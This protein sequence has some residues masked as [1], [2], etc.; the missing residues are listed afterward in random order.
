MEEKKGIYQIL[1]QVV[2][3]FAKAIPNLVGAILVLVIGWIIAKVVAKA[4]ATVLEKLGVDKAANK[5][6]QIDFMQKA[7]LNLMPSKVIPGLVYYIILL[8]FAMVSTEVLQMPVV[9]KMMADL[10]AFIPNLIAGFILFIF[11]IVLAD[12][13]KSLTLTACN[14]LGIPSG[15]VMSN[16]VFYLVFLTLTITALEQASIETTLLSTNLTILVAGLVAAFSIGYGLA[17][18]DTMANYLASF[19]TKNKVKTGD[20]VRVSGVTGEVM[21]VDGSSLTI[22]TEDR[23]VIIPLKKLTSENLE[24]LSN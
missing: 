6:N 21:M 5:I 13:L 10:I 8:I 16:F 12:F 14:S 2:T 3:D 11:G 1:E 20:I 22:Q 7:N 4:I 9:S 19:Y 24:I 17:S 23:L 18:K 15:K